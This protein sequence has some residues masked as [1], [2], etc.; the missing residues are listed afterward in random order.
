[1]GLRVTVALK[2]SST[3][4]AWS[5][6]QERPVLG[7]LKTLLYVLKGELQERRLEKQAGVKLL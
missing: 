4:Q 2:A 6:K 7:E 1:M 5:W 3:A